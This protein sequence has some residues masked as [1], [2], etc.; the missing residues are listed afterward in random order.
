M[1]KHKPE[2]ISFKADQALVQAL[3]GV[4]NR[5]QFIRDAVLAALDG[6]CPLCRGTGI[7]TPEQRRHWLS[8]TKDHRVEKCSRCR[9][10]HLV[11]EHSEGGQGH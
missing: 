10:L 5:S 2:V 9:A 6:V 3:A 8:F 1:K 4:P 7:L 11:C